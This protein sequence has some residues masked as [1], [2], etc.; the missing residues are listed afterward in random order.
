M[1]IPEYLR[2]DLR[3]IWLRYNGLVPDQ[4]LREFIAVVTG[5]PQPDR[6]P[7]TVQDGAGLDFIYGADPNSGSQLVFIELE[8][9]LHWAPV[10]VAA[11]IAGT[12]G[13]FE[14]LDPGATSSSL[15]ESLAE[16]SR[17]P[18]FES[19][20]DRQPNWDSD[21][22]EDANAARDEAEQTEAG[23]REAY[24]DLRCPDQRGP[25]DDDEVNRSDF[26]T[27]ESDGLVEFFDPNVEM[28]DTMP[29]AI[30]RKVDDYRDAGRLLAALERVRESVVEEDEDDDD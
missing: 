26:Y 20:R 10:M 9:A 6:G 7:V 24:A 8:S 19:F 14:E 16:R 4:Q 22:D 11:E 29:E 3:T 13:R 5:E 15:R 17:Y 18:D 28:C 2:E 1:S 12:W 27:W 23:L 25:L 30:R 21:E